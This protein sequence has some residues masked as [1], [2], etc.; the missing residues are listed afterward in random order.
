LFRDKN[1]AYI[2]D[3]LP[4]LHSIVSLCHDLPVSGTALVHMVY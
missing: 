2:H 4:T 1:T 3:Y